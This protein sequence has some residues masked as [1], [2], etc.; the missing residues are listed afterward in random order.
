MASNFEAFECDVA[1][2][3]FIAT[4]NDLHGMFTSPPPSSSLLPPPSLPH[5]NKN[6]ICNFKKL[7]S[8]KFLAIITVLNLF[9]NFLNRIKLQVLQI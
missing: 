5:A 1:H 7:S 4:A 6:N 9:E 8:G 3:R 2:G